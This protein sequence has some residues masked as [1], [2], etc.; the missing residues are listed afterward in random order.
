[1]GLIDIV[2]N[3]KLAKTVALTTALSLGVLIGTPEAHAVSKPKLDKAVDIILSNSFQTKK[4]QQSVSMCTTYNHY[5]LR[6]N[7]KGSTITY[8]LKEL[9]IKFWSRSYKPVSDWPMFNDGGKIVRYIL[10]INVRQGRGS[11]QI[12][13]MSANGSIESGYCR[14][15]RGRSFHYPHENAKF[16]SGYETAINVLFKNYSVKESKLESLKKKD[17]DYIKGRQRAKEE[18]SRIKMNLPLYRK[19][20]KYK[21]YYKP[22]QRPNFFR[23]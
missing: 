5:F 7:H 4:F 11:L 10:D 16:H 13:D 2:R 20:F 12:H 21:S 18:A 3:S 17:Q 19:R 15:K 1:M 22:P 23:R 8:T 9:P 6:T 14:N